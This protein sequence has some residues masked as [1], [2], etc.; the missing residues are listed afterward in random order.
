MQSFSTYPDIS[1][2]EKVDR[3]S[4]IP[5][6]EAQLAKDIRWNLGGVPFE[7]CDKLQNACKIQRKNHKP[8]Q[9]KHLN[10]SYLSNKTGHKLHAKTVH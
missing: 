9:P 2:E 5:S 10:L 1:H 8:N 3:T 7:I 6:A 4:T